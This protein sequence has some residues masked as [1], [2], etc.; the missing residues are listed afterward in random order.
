MIIYQALT[1]KQNL[2]NIEQ[3]LRYDEHIASTNA[4]VIVDNKG[5]ITGWIDNNIPLPVIAT[6]E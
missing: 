4:T 5:N 2:K 3:S 6:G 1:Q